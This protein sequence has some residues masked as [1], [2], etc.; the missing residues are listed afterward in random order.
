MEQPLQ[1]PQGRHGHRSRGRA[2]QTV[3]NGA[4]I[5]ELK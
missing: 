3:S 1:G 4:V 5:C 2:S